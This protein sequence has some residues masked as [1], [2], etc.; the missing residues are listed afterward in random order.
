MDNNLQQALKTEGLKIIQTWQIV[1][2]F[3]AMVLYGG[4]VYAVSQ[5]RLDSVEKKQNEFSIWKEEYI[6]D[7]QQFQKE[8]MQE[9]Y[10]IKS[11]QKL[12]KNKLGIRD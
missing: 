5:F 12:I 7:T 3:A 4:G 10:E 11:D 1:L 6:R 9:L 8:L 2:A